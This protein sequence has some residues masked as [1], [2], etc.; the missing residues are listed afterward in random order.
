MEKANLISKSVNIS[1]IT[2]ILNIDQSLYCQQELIVDNYLGKLNSVLDT[3]I[4][5]NINFVFN[6]KKF[7]A[8]KNS[9]TCLKDTI[10]IYQDTFGNQEYVKS[11]IV[12]NDLV[13]YNFE[14]EVIYFKKDNVYT[15]LVG[16]ESMHLNK[17][18]FRLIRPIVI[19]T[20]ESLGGVMIH[21]SAFE[22]MGK[23]CVMCG[24]S[25][26]GK[27]TLLLKLLNIP[28]TLFVA[29]DRIIIC[30][31][32][33]KYWVVPVPMPT[34]LAIGTI[35]GNEKLHAKLQKIG[36]SQSQNKAVWDSYLKQDVNVKDKLE[37]INKDIEK[38]FNKPLSNGAVLD[39]IIFPK[40]QFKTKELIEVNKIRNMEL[41][42][43]I[44]NSCYTPND[45]SYPND[46]IISSSSRGL[47]NAL[48]EKL[49]ECNSGK[50]LF[51]KD[52]DDRTLNDVL[53]I[54]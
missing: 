36:F 42:K 14:E 39:K 29:N 26:N 41:L 49:K 2:F 19:K 3:G 9:F 40:I 38:I 12:D 13:Y 18:L 17:I 48:I 44:S 20:Y 11:F 7:L 45:P 24:Q 53:E 4:T 43:I 1:G 35:I 28:D 51:S 54:V 31:L 32:K 37:I 27:T 16:V 10:L 6:Q 22:R 5:Y 50:I 47:Q 8:I 33:G 23:A 21:A 52:I 46:W 34:K 30:P 15:I 25:G